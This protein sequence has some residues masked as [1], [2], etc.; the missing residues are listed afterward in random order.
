MPSVGSL[1]LGAGSAMERVGSNV[2]LGKI[3]Q[4]LV[5]HWLYPGE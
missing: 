2:I 3:P 1:A 4:D 5:I